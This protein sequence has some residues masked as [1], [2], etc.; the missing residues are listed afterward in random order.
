LLLPP[1]AAGAFTCSQPGVY[2]YQEPEATHEFIFS[3]QRFTYRGAR[4][5]SL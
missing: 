1:G 3:N 2:R 4:E 5:I